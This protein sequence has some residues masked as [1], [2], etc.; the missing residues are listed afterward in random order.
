[1][2]PTPPLRTRLTELLG[3]DHPIMLAGM[4]GVAYAELVAAVSEAGGFGTLGASFMR[5]EKLEKELAETRART[6]KPFG[7][8]ALTA[9]AEDVRRYTPMITAGGTTLYVSGLGVDAETVATMH[10]AGLLVGSLCGKVRH[11]VKAVEAGVDL[12][13]ATGTEGGGHTGTV[14]TMAL[15]PGVVDAVEGR[16]PVVAGGGIVDGRGLAAA[17]ALGADGV[18]VGTRFAASVEARRLR[19]FHEAMIAAREDG[20]VITRAYSGKTMRVLRNEW[21]DHFEAHPEELRP[22]PQ[23]RLYAIEQAVT[24]LGA[25]D[26]S[27]VDPAREAYLCGQAVGSVHEIRTA[28]EIVSD[29]AHSAAEI[30]DRI[31]PARTVDRV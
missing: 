29:M 2:T 28:A 27:G 20:T 26:D 19:G 25:R 6:A 23:Q 31:A 10:E 13:I 22:F 24:H 17:L 5:P 8:N 16:V 15:I 9:V 14:A 18:W 3:V 1:M 30:L 4:G 7:V 12:V 11:A 21:T